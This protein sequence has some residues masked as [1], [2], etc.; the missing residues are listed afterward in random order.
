MA[1]V[2]VVFLTAIITVETDQ[3][4]PITNFLKKNIK[5][6]VEQTIKAFVILVKTTMCVQIISQ[7]VKNI[8]EQ[9]SNYA[10]IGDM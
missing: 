8:R 9:Y 10:V 5:K 2:H 3:I 1:D 4:Y 6:K 7:G